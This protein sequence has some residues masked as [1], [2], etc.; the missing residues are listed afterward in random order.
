MRVRA[1]VRIGPPRPPPFPLQ[2]KQTT[3]TQQTHKPAHPSTLPPPTPS[4]YFIDAARFVVAPLPSRMIVLA[5]LLPVS[6]SARV[7]LPCPSWLSQDRWARSNSDVSSYQSSSEEMGVTARPVVGSIH[8]SS[9]VY[10]ESPT[11]L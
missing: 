4:T 7:R 11:I 8:L 10:L 6:L 1:W 2:T 3:P 5:Y 9:S